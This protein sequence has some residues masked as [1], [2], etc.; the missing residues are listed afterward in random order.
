MPQI[1]NICWL[2]LDTLA[3]SLVSLQTRVKFLV[4]LEE[5][6]VVGEDANSIT[7]HFAVFS[8]IVRKDNCNCKVVCFDLLC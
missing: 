4:A 8:V 6:I 2:C 7:V 1:Q 3:D 5:L